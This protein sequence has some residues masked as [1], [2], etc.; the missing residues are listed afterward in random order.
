MPLVSVIIATKNRKGILVQN[1]RR[2]AESTFEDKETIV[3]DD[4][5]SDGTADLVVGLFPDVKLVRLE[6]SVGPPMARNAG[7][8]LAKGE[9][10]FIMDDD[11]YVEPGAFEKMLKVFAE[12]AQTAA[13]TFRI[14]SLADGSVNTR[15]YTQPHCKSIWTIATGFR[16]DAARQVGGFTPLSVFHGDEFDYAVRLIDHGYNIRYAPEIQAFDEGVGHRHQFPVARLVNIGNWIL[17]F[18]DLFP[19]PTAALFSA[20]AITAF[21]LRSVRE[22]SCLPFL[23]GMFHAGW[24]LAAVLRH[25][26]VVSAET[27]A[28]FSDPNLLPDTYNIPMRRKARHKIALWLSARNK[29]TDS[30]V[31]PRS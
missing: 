14:T 2:L 28:L 30:R 13:I 3:V 27:V 25:R 18:F 22:R 11:S 8:A 10:F 26:H 19:A 24:N 31:L 17:I 9:Y 29:Q 23:K 16:A 12:D 15:H 21:A 5:S 4:G 6:K 20:R 1:L 7:M